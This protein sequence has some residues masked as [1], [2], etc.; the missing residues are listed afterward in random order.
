MSDWK[1]SKNELVDLL[2][3]CW[4][5]IT[6]TKKDGTE[7]ELVAAPWARCPP[8]SETYVNHLNLITVFDDAIKQWRTIKIDSIISAQWNETDIL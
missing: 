1:P 3:N 2:K 5:T 6:F 7:R 4:V 8:T